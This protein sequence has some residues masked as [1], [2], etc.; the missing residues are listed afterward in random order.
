MVARLLLSAKTSGETISVPAFFALLTGETISSAASSA[1][2]HMGNDP[3][4]AGVLSGSPS[5]SGS[6]VT[7]LVTAGVP[8]TVY[9]IS[10]TATTNQ[11]RVLTI[12]G[13]VA[14]VGDPA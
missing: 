11:S 3:A 14:V 12:F 1:S 6:T 7:Q 8:G 13:F 4:P 9:S 10:L 5:I 2:V